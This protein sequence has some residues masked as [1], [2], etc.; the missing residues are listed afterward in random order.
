MTDFKFIILALLLVLSSLTSTAKNVNIFS[1]KNNKT[2]Y[3][4]E[5]YSK[6]AKVAGDNGV[7]VF[8]ANTY[9]F[10]KEV[11]IKN[12]ITIILQGGRIIAEGET[13]FKIISGEKID[14]IGQGQTTLLENI[15]SKIIKKG[16]KK[17]L[18]SIIDL[19]SILK[20]N[21]PSIS[22]SN[23]NF[24]AYSGINGM[25]E[26]EKGEIKNL[27]IK[28]CKF[29][30]VYAGIVHCYSKIYSLLIKNC[31]FYG[32]RHGIRVGSYIPNGARVKNNIL[33][34]IEVIAIQLCGGKFNQISQGSTREMMSAFVNGNQIIGSAKKHSTNAY[35]NGI[36]VYGHNISIQN[37]IVR[38]FNRG[39]RIPGRKKGNRI[40]MPDGSYTDSAW[41]IKKGKRTRIAGAALY[42][43]GRNVIISNNICSNSGFRS[44][45]EIK[46]A[47]LEPYAIVSGNIL[48]G[49]SLSLHESYGVE[50]HT[51]K[52]I[53]SNNL[54]YNMPNT[55]FALR[56]LKKNTF[57]NNVIY[58]SK[59][60]FLISGQGNQEEFIAGNRLVNVK[61]KFINSQGEPVTVP[62]IVQTTPRNIIV[63][64]TDELPI[65]SK[66]HHGQIAI[67]KTNDSDNI[68]I[69]V[70]QAKKYTWKSIKAD[71]QTKFSS[72]PSVI[73]GENLIKNPSL[74][75]ESTKKF[76]ASWTTWVEKVPAEK[77]FKYDN[78]IFCAG[79]MDVGNTRG[80]SWR[81]LQIKKLEPNK[82]YR[83]SVTVKVGS[84]L[85]YATLTNKQHAVIS[86]KTNEWEMLSFDFRASKSGKTEIYLSGRQCGNDKK[87]WIKNISLH[88]LK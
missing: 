59:S 17:I 8:P 30:C 50:C 29:I 43:K 12:S 47:G 49:S 64:N 63:N 6:A 67:V 75:L 53:W 60:A 45:I 46:T 48:D 40:K 31:N 34:N 65:A 33:K 42:A 19:D 58:D 26:T 55:A 4:D 38:N 68:L 51:S 61:Y 76:P 7:I 18:P 44:V 22:V 88:L 66:R 13:L 9:K 15:K 35:K 32:G 83:L 28:N 41:L 72:A 56:P 81:L 25:S 84:D 21:I 78:N 23:L 73:T 62:T 57:L 2:I 86:Q 79:A 36:L 16:S 80:Y 37:N 87:I 69:C 24:K 71:K 1:F 27:S 20:N 74:K 70:Y 3:Y 14:F 52:A 11:E 10:K 54:L 85:T 39:E 77:L 82:K 5:A